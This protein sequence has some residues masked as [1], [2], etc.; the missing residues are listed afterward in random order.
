MIKLVS[1]IL[2]LLGSVAAALL[3][4]GKSSLVSKQSIVSLEKS[5]VDE[6]LKIEGRGA[7]IEDPSVASFIESSIS[8]L[9]Q[10]SNFESK[11]YDPIKDTRIDGTWKLLY[12][13]SVSTNSPIQRSLTGFEGVKVYQVVNINDRRGS[14]LS[15]DDTDTDDNKQP[16]VSN[17]V[18]FKGLQ[19]RLR[20]TALASTED[21]MLVTPRRGDGKIL[22]LAPFGVSNNALPRS[23]RERLVHTVLSRLLYCYE[24]HHNCYDNQLY[25]IH[26]NPNPNPNPNSFSAL[27]PYTLSGFLPLS[28]PSIR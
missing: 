12:T 9:E 15:T 27:K 7:R 2:I 5:L 3:T 8:L 22:G 23:S 25:R 16:D 1:I 14:F 19:S 18:V 28:L 24:E 10:S 20:V 21:T 13:S 26:P 4:H 17:V 11:E 6:L